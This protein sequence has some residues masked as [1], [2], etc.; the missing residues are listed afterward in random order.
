MSEK[1]GKVKSGS[2]DQYTV[3]WDKKTKEVWVDDGTWAGKR[4]IDF[5]ADSSGE[6]IMTAKAYLSDR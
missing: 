5:R 2:G 3:S 1:I 4:K 6:A